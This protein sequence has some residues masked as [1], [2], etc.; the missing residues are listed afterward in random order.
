M[1][2]SQVSGL[3]VQVLGVA[4]NISRY[5]GQSF[6]PLTPETYHLRPDI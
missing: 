1:A 6:V 4:V 5:R 2:L 3:G